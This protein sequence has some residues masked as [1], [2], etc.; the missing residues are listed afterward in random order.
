MK[1]KCIYRYREQTCSYEWGVE[2]EMGKIE[3]NAKEVQTII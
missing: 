2:A 3:V 1:Q